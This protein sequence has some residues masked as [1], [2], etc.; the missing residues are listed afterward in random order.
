MNDVVLIE[1][2][3]QAE[4][5]ICAEYAKAYS[6]FAVSNCAETILNVLDGHLRISQ[7]LAQL[8]NMYSLSE[9]EQTVSPGEIIA[10]KHT[11]KMTDENQ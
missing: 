4:R 7:K 8:Q 10:F 3:R 6:D 2:L 9:S 11:Q 5:G 1:G